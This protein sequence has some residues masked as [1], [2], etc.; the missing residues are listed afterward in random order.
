RNEL[1]EYLDYIIDKK[2]SDGKPLVTIP[3]NFTM[4]ADSMN[5][6]DLR[7]V[8]DK[9]PWCQY[10]FQESYDNILKQEFEGRYDSYLQETTDIRITP[11]IIAITPEINARYEQ[12]MSINDDDDNNNLY[13]QD[14]H[15][16]ELKEVE[17]QIK[18]IDSDL[19][20]FGRVERLVDK[21]FDPGRK[22]DT[23]TQQ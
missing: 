1:K 16:L 23:L 5:R 13:S 21:D 7:A 10:L 4:I 19:E 12:I 3:D 20:Q 14:E 2:G 11:A 22:E 18:A 9:A 15:M 17:A 6:D 8:G